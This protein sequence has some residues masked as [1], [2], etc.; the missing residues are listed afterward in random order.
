VPDLP[1][2]NP[3]QYRA[4]FAA[5]LTPLLGADA[6]VGAFILAFNNAAFDA[7]LRRLLAPR[8]EQR[9]A[10]LAEE[11][12]RALRQGSDPAVPA[13]DLAVFLRMLAVGYQG[14]DPVEIRAAGPWEVQ[15]NLVRAFRPARSSAGS[16]ASLRAPFDPAGFNFNRPFLR[17][18]TL[19]SGVLQGQTVDLF[20]NKFPFVPLQTILVP[21]REHGLPQRL[22]EQ[23]HRLAWCLAAELG[24]AWPSPVVGYNSQGAYA[25]VNHLHFHLAMRGGPMPIADARWHHNGGTERYPL[26]CIAETDADA[27]WRLITKRQDRDQ[28]FNLVYEPG[29]V[30]IIDRRCQGDYAL[31]PGAGGHAWYE[32]GGGLICFD[33][34]RY[35]RATPDEIAQGIGLAAPGAG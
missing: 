22:R 15:F 31:P 19:W 10:E 32:L 34:E 4:A 18:E 16:P 21:Q 1:L 3:E 9:F 30:Y 29:R 25:S 17:P 7:E 14:L 2:Q 12:R 11:F 24:L 20:Y 35:R 5:G 28:P 26:P 8:L 23:D 6:G 13:D 27:A 33:N